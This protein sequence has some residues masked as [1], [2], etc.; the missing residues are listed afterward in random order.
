[1]LMNRYEEL[2]FLGRMGAALTRVRAIL[3]RTRD[4]RSPVDVP[5]SYDDKYVLAEFLGRASVASLMLALE[6]LGLDEAGLATLRGWA[7]T[8]SVTLRLRAQEE[9]SFVREVTRKV[10]SAQ[11]HVTEVRTFLGGKT[12]RT[13]KIV[14]T[15]T[16]YL[17]S[18]DAR[19]EHRRSRAPDPREARRAL[20]QG[21]A[22]RDQEHHPP[23][24]EAALR[25]A[26]AHRPRPHVGPPSDRRRRAGGLR[27]RPRAPR[28]PHAAPQ[29]A[30]R[31]GAAGLRR[32]PGVVRGRDVAL[33]LGGLPG[34][35]RARLDLAA[36]N[37]AEVFVPAVPLFDR[38][39]GG[40]VLPVGYLTAFLDEERR[41]LAEK[42]ARLDAAFPHDGSV[43]TAHEAVLLVTLLHAQDVCRHFAGGVDFIE[44]M[45]R[46]QL[47]EAIGKEVTPAEFAEYMA[48]HHRKLFKPEY[49]P[50]AFSYA[51]RRPGHDPEGALGIEARVGRAM[52][53]AI[54]TIVA[55]RDATRPMSFALDASTRVSFL[56]ERYLHGWVAHQFS[57]RT[58]L[59]LSL[60][61]RARQFSS[62]LLLVGR[63]SS[64]DSFDPRFGIIVQNKDVLS[65]PLMLEQIPTPKEFRDAIESLS[66]E[67]QRFAKAFRGMQLEST[68]FGVCVVQIKPQ[69]ERLLKLPPDSL[70]KEI[71]LTQD[72][73]A[74][75]M[76]HQIP[77]DLLSY[78][79]P[80]E[81][82]AAVKLARVGEYVAR[83]HAVIGEAKLRELEEAQER[84]AY[85]LAETD[86]TPFPVSAPMLGFVGS[87]APF[88]PP[89]A[90]PY[91]GPP[92]MGGFPP[93][94]PSAM[95][96]AAGR[97]AAPPPPPQAPVAP[98]RAAAPATPAP[99][100]AT[101]VPT[102]A[103][104]AEAATLD[105]GARGD[106][107]P[108][109]YT[110]I[111]AAL[112]RKFEA[113]DDDGALRPTILGVGEV[114]SRSAQ[115]SLLAER[116]L[117]DLG[118]DD[119]KVE[120]ARAFDLIDALTKSGAMPLE[121]AS[122]HV[123]IAA[124]HCFDDTLLN[125]VIQRN[126]NPIER[127]ERS[128]VIVA[129]TIHGRPAAD[130]LADDQRERFFLG[131]P[132]LRP[133]EP[134]RAEPGRDDPPAQA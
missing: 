126:V 4:P 34:A 71:K 113:L 125:T 37:A 72:L 54:S 114:W 31:R 52:P 73:L 127:V 30:G 33:P 22:R 1:M 36:I 56:G 35:G 94:S 24:P 14:T 79:G 18:F 134:V 74:L 95:P 45:L 118:P 100:P 46:A 2:E 115:K 119:Q 121:H 38:G 57:G 105:P 104:P 111:P 28:L 5:H 43:I 9:C 122:L 59:A 44:G 78:D 40:E 75:F 89:G 55:R 41:S 110:R 6:T 109:D 117:T 130:L 133:D 53:E 47:V 23:D 81:A 64:A 13:D 87:A 70:T 20:V 68:L 65:I 86:S 60:V 97:M 84:E 15:I 27:R 103:R 129:T 120:R 102:P 80:E 66:P 11:E 77:S 116:A 17:W 49:R 42:R 101:P 88:G 61:A 12:T 98:P 7:A 62:F 108:Q 25:G 63:I 90:M 67:Q 69:L 10:E 82:E 96:V 76:E 83:M 3:D 48:F 131:S 107:D 58:D 92:G 85:R 21:R 19:H 29:P 124:T 99:T 132:R 91:Q 8:R 16:E 93:P 50:Q 39:G 26:P 123:V 112:D 51:V 32:R 106:D 128:S